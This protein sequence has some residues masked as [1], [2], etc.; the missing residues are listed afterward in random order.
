[1]SVTKMPFGKF[2]GWGLDTIPEDYLQWAVDEIDFRSPQLRRAILRELERR[3]FGCHQAQSPP[4]GR[5]T[6][7]GEHQPFVDEL[8]HAGYRAAAKSHHPD[9]GGSGD[10]F[11][12][13]HNA[14][15]WLKERL[16]K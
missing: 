13:F 1:M 10:Q 3:T 8:L 2:K 11:K 14:Y 15:E 12:A 6:V 5:I 7:P 16:S 4:S 9:L